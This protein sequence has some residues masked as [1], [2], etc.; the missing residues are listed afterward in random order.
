MPASVIQRQYDEV[1]AEH[2]DLDPYRV[3]GRSLDRAVSQI[4]RETEV[5]RAGPPLRV[6]DLG[7][8]TGSFLAKLGARLGPLR[9][10]GIDISQKMIDIA[11]AKVPG[12][13]A[14]VDDAAKL[15]AHFPGE[16]F[17]LICTHYV[18]GFVPMDELAT[19][20]WDRLAPGGYWSL[21]GGTKG[22]FPVLRSKAESKA[23]RTLFGGNSVDVDDRVCN[24]A[25]RAEV[26]QSFE[27]HGFDVRRCETFTPRLDFKN[28][29]EFLAFAYYGG[30]LAPFVEALGL[31]RIQGAMK[32]AVD[33]AFFPVTDYHS[34]EIALAKKDGG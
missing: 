29:D 16:S 25:D 8:G 28:L 17:D 23:A 11:S 31:H 30:W 3:T 13:N 14:A 18:T 9:P 15:D 10:Y 24:P 20:I 21:V 5:V 33:A 2:Y 27:A 1:I 22:G 34:I 7:V 6:L 32:A 19:K 26:L 4:W 12:L